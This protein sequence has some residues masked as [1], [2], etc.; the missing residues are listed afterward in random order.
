M[1]LP[2]I[3][4]NTPIYTIVEEDLQVVARDRLHRRL[5]QE[6]LHTASHAFANGMDWWDMA[7]CAVDFAVAEHR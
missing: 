6:E 2:P 3:L 5:T 1:S 4:L 7:Q